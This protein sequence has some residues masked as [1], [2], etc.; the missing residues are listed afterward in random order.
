MKVCYWDTEDKEVT[1]VK[2]I[3]FYKTFIRCYTE[4]NDEVEIPL[5]LML[6]IEDDNK[7][8]VSKWGMHIK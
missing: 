1:N 5:Y 6:T 4:D 8:E 7:Q 3:D 2:S